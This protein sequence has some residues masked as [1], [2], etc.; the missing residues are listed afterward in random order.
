MC[1]REGILA[2]PSGRIRMYGE[3][4]KCPNHVDDE[5][6]DVARRAD[7]CPEESALKP[8]WWHSQ[9]VLVNHASWHRVRYRTAGLSSQNGYLL[10]IVAEM[11][12]QLITLTPQ[13]VYVGE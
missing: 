13:G 4:R 12:G 10:L 9:V 11:A 2:V 1:F 3:P 5:I 8:L 7:G 6:G